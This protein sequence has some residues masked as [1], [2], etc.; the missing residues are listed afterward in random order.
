[1]FFHW[2]YTPLFG[3]NSAESGWNWTLSIVSLTVVIRTLLIRC[4]SSRST[5]PV[6]C[7]LLQPKIA[8]LQKKHSHDQEKLGQGHED[9]PPRR[10]SSPTASCLPLL[11]QMPI[12]L[13]LFRVLGCVVGQRARALLQGQPRARVVPAERRDL[14]RPPHADRIFPVTSF[15]PT[16]AVGIVLVVAMVAVFFVTQLQLMRK[17]L[18]PGR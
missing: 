3:E 2:L 7:S 1:M 6:T 16:Q 9:V 5:P 8:E 10:V 14:R 15:G 13:A 4:S 11:L 18:P 17:N 12:F